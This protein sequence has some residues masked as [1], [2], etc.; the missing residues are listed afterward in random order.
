MHTDAVKANLIPPEMPPKEVGFVYASEADLL[1]K[2]LFGMPATEW[3]KANP[4]AKGNIRDAAT[5]EQLVVM[6]SL[7]SQNALLVQ[8]GM[9]GYQ[10]LHLLNTLARA[11]LQSLLTN[12]SLT[13]LR[14]GS[15]LN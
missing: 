11:Q 8:Q 5:M 4:E 7:E 10:R 15:L 6:S 13:P 9:P 1:N 2:A 12:P 3:R 14:G